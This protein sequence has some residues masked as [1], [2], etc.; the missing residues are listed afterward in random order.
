MAGNGKSDVARLTSGFVAVFLSM[1]FGFR[2]NGNPALLLASLFFV[3][4]CISDTLNA[5]IHNLSVLALL[6]AAVVLNFYQQG[7]S[8]LT[9]SCLG[10]TV[11]ICLLLGPYLFGGMGAGDVKALGALGA[12]IGPVPIFQVFLY[13]ALFGGILGIIHYVLNRSLRDRAAAG[14]GAF[15]TFI[16]TQNVGDLKPGERPEKLRFPYAAA[17]AY[18]FFAYISWGGLLPWD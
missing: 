10:F 12:L 4:I 8:G 14:M 1:W 2:W 6:V 13:T 17:I 16:L 3:V 11:G 9:N 5:K 15:K 7:F 18:G